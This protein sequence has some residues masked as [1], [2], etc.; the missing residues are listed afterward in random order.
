MR[1]GEKVEDIGKR[2][3][4]FALGIIRLCRRIEQRRSQIDSILAKQLLRAAT[5]IGANIQEAKAAESRADFIHKY[6]I[7][8]KEAKET[9]YWLRLI[10]ASDII[11]LEDVK[12]AA[13]ELKEILSIIT[14]ILLKTK[15]RTYV[16]TK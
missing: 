13:Q 15:K 16:R 3:F 5:S 9:L 10:A 4:R 14:A 8:Q 7:A 6:A 12:P 11:P 1:E 2:S